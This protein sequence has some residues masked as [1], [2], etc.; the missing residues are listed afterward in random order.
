MTW[1]T[2]KSLVN[3]DSDVKLNQLMGPPGIIRALHKFS[4]EGFRL[5][6]WFVIVLNVNLAILNLLPIPILDGGHILFAGIEAII[7][8]PLN[9]KFINAIQMTFL[10]LFLALMLY[11]TFFDVK[12]WRGDVKTKDLYAKQARLHIEPKFFR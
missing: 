3:K 5:L 11:V 1:N 12:R 2:L 10:F 8:R 9:E 7:R 6:F 4:T